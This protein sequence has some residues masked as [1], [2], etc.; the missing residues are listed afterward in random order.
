MPNSRA[1]SPRIVFLS[2]DANARLI[3]AFLAFGVGF[4]IRPL[5]A[6]LIGSYGDRAGRK[7]ALTLTL[8]LMVSGTAIIALMVIPFQSSADDARTESVT[9]FPQ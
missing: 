9:A 4:L 3:K 7:L 6:L 2:E 8:L 1:T 5:G